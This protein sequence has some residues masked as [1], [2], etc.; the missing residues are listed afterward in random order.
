VS[1]RGSRDVIAA[2]NVLSPVVGL[3]QPTP[4]AASPPSSSDSESESESGMET[5]DLTEAAS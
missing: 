5:N 3:T 4:G 2:I 1:S